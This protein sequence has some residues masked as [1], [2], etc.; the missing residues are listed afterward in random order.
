VCIRAYQRPAEL[1]EAIA[2]VLGQT[3]RDLEVVVSDD[4][5]CLDG[6]V[7][8]FRDPRVHY[9]RN[10]EPSGPAGNLRTVVGLAR[11][12]LLAV[13]D[14][15]DMWLPGFLETVVQRFDEDAE[16]GVVVTN[17][18]LEVRGRRIARRA[19]LPE[20]RHEDVLP[21]VLAHE[22][23]PPCA[24][25]FRREAW[26]QG[27]REHPLTDDVVGDVT[28]NLRTAAAGWPFFFVDEPLAV[29]R[30]HSAQMSLSDPRLAARTAATFEQFRFPD[31]TCEAMR[32]ARLAEARLKHANQL[33]RKGCVRRAQA[34][35]RA[36]RA[37]APGLGFRGV[38]AVT[39]IRGPVARWL[40]RHPFVT[41]LGLRLWPHLRPE[42]PA[43]AG[44]GLARK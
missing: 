5:G 35:I 39:G 23:G 25:V 2:S 12:R 20:G 27:E 24:A 42:V 11:G 17:R 9:H 7:R 33:L 15:D 36:A 28:V 32:R 16:L 29:Y 26:E 4:S 21:T 6:A 30:V 14:D 37:V 41:R 18:Y 43:H 44:A 19:V 38:L 13:L 34:E 1:Q 31:R 22:L 10:P 40:A 8:A 3:F